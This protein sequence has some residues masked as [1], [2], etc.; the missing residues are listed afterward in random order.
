MGS[1]E[2]QVLGRIDPSSFIFGVIAPEE[3]GEYDYFALVKRGKF[4]CVEDLVL[5]W[6]NALA[7]SEFGDKF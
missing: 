7:L 2:D 6:K 3:E 4:K 1:V 5:G